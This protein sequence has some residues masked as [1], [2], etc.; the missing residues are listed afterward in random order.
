VS[1][2]TGRVLWTHN[3]NTTGYTTPAVAY[4]RVYVGGF[5]GYIRAYNAATGRQVWARYVGG[6]IL[7]PPVVIGNLV[8]A[9]NLETKTFAV[10]AS[11]GKLVWRIGMGKYSP[12]I[13]TD[14]HYYLT[15]NGMLI[16]FRGQH[17]PPE[18]KLHAAKRGAKAKSAAG[19]GGARAVTAAS[20]RR[21]HAKQR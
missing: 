18:Q 8:F 3:L 7:G 10:R 1:A 12:L 13:A 4:G 16:A 2:R 6:R 15:L 20:R 14:D 19:G 11:D 9:A 17:S 21:S 5:D